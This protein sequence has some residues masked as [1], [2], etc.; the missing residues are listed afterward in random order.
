MRTRVKVCGITSVADALVAAE[1]GADAIGL[2]FYKPSPRYVDVDTAAVIAR[3]LPPFVTVVGLFV[4]AT[5]AIIARTVAEV[6]IDLLQFHGDESPAHCREQGKPWIRAVRMRDGVDIGAE[7]A[8]FEGARGLLLDTFRAGVPGGTGET[9]DWDRV[10]GELAGR[11]ILAGGLDPDN[12]ADAVRR[13]RPYA[14]DVSG[15]VERA[16]GI[17]DPGRI[18]RF[19]DEVRS[20]E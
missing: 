7:M 3:E 5:E 6:G 18:R 10:P 16:K 20:A 8:R 13:L 4:D 2:V 19:I 1:C 12:V 17:K 15:G 14:V 11:V 9:F